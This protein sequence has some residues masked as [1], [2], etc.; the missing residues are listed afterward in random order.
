MLALYIKPSSLLLLRW[1]CPRNG[2]VDTNR[3]NNFYN[4]PNIAVEYRAQLI[5]HL[6]RH[7]FISVHLRKCAGAD[8]SRDSYFCFL[9]L[10]IDEQFPKFFICDAHKSHPKFAN[11]FKN[12]YNIL[13]TGSQYKMREIVISI[14]L[15][16]STDTPHSAEWGVFFLPSFGGRDIGS[17]GKVDDRLF[18]DAPDPAIAEPGDPA[19]GQVLIYSISPQP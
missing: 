9:K 7:I 19:C 3:F 10:F 8:S 17:H 4:I 5:Q 12:N 6:K 11:F 2:A 15:I 1:R 16:I 18:R 14:Y 13:V